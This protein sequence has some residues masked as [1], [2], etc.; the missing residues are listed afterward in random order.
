[1]LTRGLVKN[2]VASLLSAAPAVS[3]PCSTGSSNVA[4]RAPLQGVAKPAPDLLISSLSTIVNTSAARVPLPACVDATRTIHNCKRPDTGRRATK[5]LP[6]RTEAAMQHGAE[7]S[8]K[9]PGQQ[10]QQQQ[11]TA[12]EHHQLAAAEQLHQSEDA[13]MSQHAAEYSSLQLQ[14]SP[15][16]QQQQQQQQQQPQLTAVPQMAATK[17][18][19]AAAAEFVSMQLQQQ[20]VEPPVPAA[21]TA[22][23]DMRQS[24][25]EL[26]PLPPQ[27]QQQ[28]QHQQA[29]NELR[30]PVKAPPPRPTHFLAL[31]VS[32]SP[33]V[34]A[35]IAAVHAGLVAAAPHLEDALLDPATAHLTIMVLNLPGQEQEA[36]AAVALAEL[37]P[38]LQAQQLLAPLQLQ[39]RGLSHFRSQLLRVLYLDVAP[40]EV[41]ERLLRLGSAAVQHFTAAAGGSLAL[42]DGGRGFTPHVTVAKTSRLGGVQGRPKVSEAAWA[43]AADLDAGS[44]VVAEIQICSMQG[45][46]AGQYYK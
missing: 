39:L 37:G 8:L 32:H 18:C 46:R 34:R 15:K 20:L 35:A 42:N 5:V 2:S 4:C 23:E 1:M 25:E 29:V 9:Q 27:Q 31:Q 7:N 21:E 38:V 12:A 24:A 14:P 43:A 40:G 28:Q 16:Q 11:Q 44:V 19:S 22:D 33:Q 17:T 3:L 6:S 10:E 36:A 30:Q 13:S 45:R 26:P 41:R